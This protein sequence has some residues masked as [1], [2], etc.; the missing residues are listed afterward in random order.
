MR[1]II[2][3][4]LA[5]LLP[6]LAG[7][8]KY[9][10]GDISLLPEYENAGAVYLTQEGQRIDN[11]L[12]FN[13]QKGMN[14]MRVRLFVDPAAYNGPDDDPNACQNLEYITPLCRRIKDAGFA[15]MLDFH[16]S[17]TW[18]DPAK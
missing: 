9:A 6:Q 3:I 12:E 7:A 8:V 11:L 5:I 10:G 18:A 16:Y 2:T 14:I 15:L 1:Q 13:R 4:I 17:D